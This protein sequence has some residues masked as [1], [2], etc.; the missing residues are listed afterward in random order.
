MRK[1]NVIF[2]GRYLKFWYVA[3]AIIIIA[4]FINHIVNTR[5]SKFEF[6]LYNSNGGVVSE[7]IV[8]KSHLNVFISESPVTKSVRPVKR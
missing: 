4:M 8:D 5:V 3:C 1:L 7:Q 6:T 2:T